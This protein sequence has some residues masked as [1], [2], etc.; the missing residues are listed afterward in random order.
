MLKEEGFLV[1]VHMSSPSETCEVPCIVFKAVL[2]VGYVFE[3]SEQAGKEG[4]S[5]MEHQTRLPMDH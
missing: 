4:A 2:L 1:V 3:T 5:K